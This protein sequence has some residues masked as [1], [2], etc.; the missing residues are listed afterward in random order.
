[1]KKGVYFS[2]T[3]PRI[4]RKP[5]YKLVA[6]AMIIPHNEVIPPMAAGETS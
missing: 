3:R 6:I 1:M 4:V 5:A 2:Y